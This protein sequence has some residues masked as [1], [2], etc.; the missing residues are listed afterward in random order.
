MNEL[1]TSTRVLAVRKKVLNNA[2]AGTTIK[3]TFENVVRKPTAETRHKS[4]ANVKTVLG[5]NAI[6]EKKQN[7][8]IKKS[9]NESRT[10]SVARS[11]TKTSAPEK[12]LMRKLQRKNS[13][14]P[15][16]VAKELEEI[17][18]KP[19]TNLKSGLKKISILAPKTGS[20]SSPKTAS[21]LSS[22][23]VSKPSPRTV[24]RSVQKPGQKRAIEKCNAD[25]AKPTT[26]VKMGLRK[27][28][29]PLNKLNI[30]C[31]N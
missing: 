5:I 12:R 19:K 3:K 16:F 4:S 9:A 17:P 6:P 28:S 20:T 21:T 24:S 11:S 7:A 22:K 18:V 25:H 29:V 8:K 13:P 14:A 10:R 23:P 15:R 30:F 27:K 26:A 2:G 1:P 31:M